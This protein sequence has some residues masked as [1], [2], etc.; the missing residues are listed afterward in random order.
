LRDEEDAGALRAFP[1]EYFAR[2]ETPLYGPLRE[3]LHLAFAEGGQ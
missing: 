2:R 3:A 1:E